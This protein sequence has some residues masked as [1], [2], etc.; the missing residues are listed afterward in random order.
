MSL[1]RLLITALA[2]LLALP[3]V[4]HAHRSEGARVRLH[5]IAVP[6]AI[7]RFSTTHPFEWRG[8]DST[9]ARRDSFVQVGSFVRSKT[10]VQYVRG[11]SVECGSRPC[12]P[13]SELAS[14]HHC[15]A[16]GPRGRC[17]KLVYVS[18]IDL[19]AGRLGFRPK[20]PDRELFL[21]TVVL[22]SGGHVSST[23]I[24]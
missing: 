10:S 15:G 6:R 17:L 19:G 5:P 4:A 12:V 11:P 21:K 2:L 23:Y 24:R 22:A 13:L 16:R 3:G 9:Y 7:G 14:R 8:R 1:P 18:I 20:G